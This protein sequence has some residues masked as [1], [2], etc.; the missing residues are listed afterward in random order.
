MQHERA[1]VLSIHGCIYL[2]FVQSSVQFHLVIIRVEFSA[3]ESQLIVLFFIAK[4]TS[5]GSRSCLGMKV[6]ADAL[7]AAAGNEM[8]ATSQ[9]AL[10]LSS[11]RNPQSYCIQMRIYN[12]MN[13]LLL[14]TR[15]G[16]GHQNRYERGDIIYSGAAH[17][18]KQCTWLTFTHPRRRLVQYV[19]VQLYSPSVRDT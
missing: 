9:V 11:S 5:C 1:M 16:D 3:S 12:E 7:P 4:R 2:Y 17:G 10:W 14:N 8:A 15:V 6:G 13:Y 19:F 18:T